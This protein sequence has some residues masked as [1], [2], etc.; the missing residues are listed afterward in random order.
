MHIC[1][2]LDNNL[3]KLFKIPFS[4]NGSS[5][6][7]LHV[8][9]SRGIMLIFTLIAA[10]WFSPIDRYEEDSLAKTENR[11]QRK[12]VIVLP[13]DGSSFQ[14]A[15]ARKQRDK[16]MIVLMHT[17]KLRRRRVSTTWISYQAR[18]G[19][20]IDVAEGTIGKH[21]KKHSMSFHCTQ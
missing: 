18:E 16:E 2:T 17:Q 7:L 4:L 3:M 6:F 5:L 14:D 19:G 12:L 11:W 15:K 1:I 20:R 13:T 10:L 8:V 21:K 9:S